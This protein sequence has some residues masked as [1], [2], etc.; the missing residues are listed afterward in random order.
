MLFITKREIEV[1]EKI[2]KI[3]YFFV[4][5]I[6]QNFIILHTIFDSSFSSLTQKY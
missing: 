5:E 4:N 1:T 6:F 2:F 3:K